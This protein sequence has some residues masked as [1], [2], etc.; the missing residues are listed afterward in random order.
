MKKRGKWTNLALAIALMTAPALLQAE[1]SNTPKPLDEQVRHELIMLPYFGVFDNLGFRVDGDKVT[2][3]GQ[4]TRPTLRSDAERVVKRIA[5]VASVDNQIELLPLSRF[6]DRIRLATLYAVYRNS[7]LYRY[8]MDPVAPIRIIVK[9]G[10]VTLEGSVATQS[11]KSVAG[12]V[13]NGV[14]GVFSVTNDL[15]VRS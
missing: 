11:E 7:M 15:Q 10:N 14:P 6:D 4:V 13:A 1:T 8:G 2:L 3:M 12:M 5:G 9:N